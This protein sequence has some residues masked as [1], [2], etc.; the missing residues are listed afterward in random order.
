MVEMM[1]PCLQLPCVQDQRNRE[2]PMF[3]IISRMSRLNS[4]FNLAHLHKCSLFFR[5]A[6]QIGPN[7]K[8]AF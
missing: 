1:K 6:M 5:I 4:I 3:H 7:M 8:I 2:D